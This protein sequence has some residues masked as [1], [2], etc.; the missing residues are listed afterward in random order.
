MSNTQDIEDLNY[1]I[2]QHAVWLSSQ[3]NLKVLA[4][5]LKGLNLRHQILETGR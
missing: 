3:I 2:R 5:L 1:V 4:T